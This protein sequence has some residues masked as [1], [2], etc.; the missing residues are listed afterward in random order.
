LL[1]ID[2][3]LVVAA[4]EHQIEVSLLFNEGPIDQD[5]QIGQHLAHGCIGQH[6]L[7]QKSGIAPDGAM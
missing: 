5:F 4:A 1:H 7:V 3:P 2:Q 6:F